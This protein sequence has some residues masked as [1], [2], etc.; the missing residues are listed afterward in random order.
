MS[1]EHDRCQEFCVDAKAL[2]A[3]EKKMPDQATLNR[4][5]RMFG[6]FGD[7]NRLKIMLAVADQ[8]LCVCELGELLGMS[9]PAVSHH[10]RRLKDLSLVKTRRQGKLVYYSL[11]DQHIRDLL[12]IGQAHLQ[13]S[14]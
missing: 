10:L 6:A 11:D 5:S 2:A 12:V 14:S 13:H 8:D 3:A 9:A 7:A 1:N 4:L